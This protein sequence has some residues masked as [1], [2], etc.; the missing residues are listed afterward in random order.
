MTGHHDYQLTVAITVVDFL[1]FYSHM[2][3]FIGAQRYKKK[4]LYSLFRCRQEQNVCV[5]VYKTHSR[6][7][8]NPTTAVG[9]EPTACEAA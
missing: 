3:R 4:N 1:F 5:C 6:T 7:A 2:C 9:I 8:A